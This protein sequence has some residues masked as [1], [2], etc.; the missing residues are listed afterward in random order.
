MLFLSS[1]PPQPNRSSGKFSS[2]SRQQGTFKRLNLRER[3]ISP[4]MCPQGFRLQS[5]VR[6][7]RHPRASQVAQDYTKSK[8]GKCMSF[9]FRFQRCSLAWNFS[10]D[11][12]RLLVFRSAGL[13]QKQCETS[14]IADS[15]PRTRAAQANQ[16]MRTPRA[17]ASDFQ[18]FDLSSLRQ[19]GW[20]SATSA[21][22]KM[23]NISSGICK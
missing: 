20:Q 10:D 16:C 3:L 8:G 12:P 17:D 1:S 9:C 2:Q 21:R 11:L 6:N 18:Y 5:K 4:D 14:V 13:K 23:E 15:P 7:P 22:Q 19:P